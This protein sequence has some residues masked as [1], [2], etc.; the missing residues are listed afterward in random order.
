[1]LN[2]ITANTSVSRRYTPE[3]TRPFVDGAKAG[4]V[5][6]TVECAFR[7]VLSPLVS[8]LVTPEILWV[9]LLPFVLYPLVYGM[10]TA[11]LGRFLPAAA[12]IAIAVPAATLRML[13]KTT[14]IGLIALAAI[15]LVL[16]ISKRIPLLN[17][18]AV[19]IL[20]I[21]SLW[22]V[23]D[24][25]IDLTRSEKLLRVPVALGIIAAVLFL[26]RK[27]TISMHPAWSAVVIVAAVVLNTGVSRG[28]VQHRLPNIILLSLDTVRAD[29]TS[30][31]G[32]S[33]DTTPE[34]KRFAAVSTLFTNATASSNFT[35]PSHTSMFTG[36]PATVHGNY[37]LGTMG[38]LAPQDTTMAEVLAAR[39]YDTYS[40]VSN[41]PPLG[42]AFGLDRGFRYLDARF[43]DDVRYTP[44][45]LLRQLAWHAQLLHV[46]RADEIE[47]TASRLIQRGAREPHPFFLFVNFMDAHAPY[48][49]PE[50]YASLFPGC[51]RGI[52][53]EPLVDGYIDEMLR[54]NLEVPPDIRSHL[55]SQ[56]DGALRFVDHHVG[57]LIQ[58]LRQYGVYDNT[59]IVITS[60]HGEAFGDKGFIG[61][62]NSV[63]QDAIHVPLLIKFPRQTSGE[64]RQEPAALTDLYATVL[65]AAA[66]RSPHES[67]GV[68]LR[69]PAPE[70]R[71]VVS[72]GFTLSGATL[73]AIRAAVS[74]RFKLV[75]EDGKTRVFDIPADPNEEHDLASALP[76]EAIAP[77]QSA[78]A[79]VAA[80]PPHNTTGKPLDPETTR[81]LR[82][83]GYLH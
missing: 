16:V 71:V 81:R 4:L 78:I 58:T 39:G 15:V 67:F 42:R 23:R 43:E 27:R 14:S 8:H 25:L 56:Y 17:P 80:L 22:F 48:A 83:L 33:R 41:A 53:T 28:T 21:G 55:I 61:H 54:G 62:G 52:A 66:C 74:A 73:R 40:V 60:D 3:V 26:L 6:A 70:S 11:A 72:E 63:Y 24:V 19:S 38:I 5:L 47:A 30:I 46:R 35:L 49:P 69:Q 29:H 12:V 79:A 76:N 44:R 31:G 10:A 50:S 13:G 7:S 1:M 77:L 57:A 59:L 36:L 65:E 64:V 2:F 9:V 32:Y 82:A 45:D 68:S 20:L 34:L 37:H 75:V 51:L 18:F